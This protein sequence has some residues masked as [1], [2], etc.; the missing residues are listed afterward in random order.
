M[1]VSLSCSYHPTRSHTSILIFLHLYQHVTIR[2]SLFFFFFLWSIVLIFVLFF[3]FQ[4]EDGIR[5]YKVTG[6]QTCALPIYLFGAFVALLSIT[7]A[8]LTLTW[9]LLLQ[10]RMIMLARQ[11]VAWDGVGQLHFVEIG[12][13]SCRER[14]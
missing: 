4:A 12:R 9:T 10:S 3:F 2:F 13:A 14:V 6:V 8:M 7:A 11:G 5:D 1:Y